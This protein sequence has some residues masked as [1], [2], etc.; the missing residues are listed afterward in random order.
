MKGKSRG[1]LV[2]REYSDEEIWQ[3]LNEW[4]GKEN[5]IQLGKYLYIVCE[6]NAYYFMKK[7]IPEIFFTFDATKLEKV[8]SIE[9]EIDGSL[10]VRLK[11]DRSEILIM[12]TKQ[13]VIKKI[14]QWV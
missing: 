9:E 13:R 12:T 4:Y 2:E 8:I 11:K 5:C 7:S 10:T 3:K 6:R 1:G 14:A